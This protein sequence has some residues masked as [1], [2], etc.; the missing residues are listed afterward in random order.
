MPTKKKPA[1]PSKRDFVER[2]IDGMTN[3]LEKGDKPFSEH[4]CRLFVA[5]LQAQNNRN[6]LSDHDLLTEWD[7]RFKAIEAWI[8]SRQTEQSIQ[9]STRPRQRRAQQPQQPQPQQFVPGPG[10]DGNAQG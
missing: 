1:A 7:T 3:R 9:A 5:L 2:A 8:N 10:F 4:E 6:L